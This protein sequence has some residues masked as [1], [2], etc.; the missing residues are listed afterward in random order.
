MFKHGSKIALRAPNITGVLK[1]AKIRARN[2]SQ[3]TSA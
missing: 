3:Y 1:Q 2:P